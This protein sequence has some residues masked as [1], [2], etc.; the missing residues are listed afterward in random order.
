MERKGSEFP[1]KSQFSGVCGPITGHQVIYKNFE[2]GN[3]VIENEDFPNR[4][5]TMFLDLLNEDN[6]FLLNN[7]LEWIPNINNLFAKS[8]KLRSRPEVA[9]RDLL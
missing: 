8:A 1:L 9:S 5:S 4:L 2:K 7:K 6:Q 3:S